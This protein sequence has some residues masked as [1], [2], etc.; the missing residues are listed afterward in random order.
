MKKKKR[1]N[2]KFKKIKYNIIFMIYKSKTRVINE[3]QMYILK[4]TIIILN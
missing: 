4:L 1:M 3:I 2:M